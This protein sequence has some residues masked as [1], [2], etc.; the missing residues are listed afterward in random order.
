MFPL[1]TRLIEPSVR[2]FQTPLASKLHT[3]KT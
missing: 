1:A 2:A 3:T